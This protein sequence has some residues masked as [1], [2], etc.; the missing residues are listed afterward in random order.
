[1]ANG[2]I[3][4]RQRT[5]KDFR[6]GSLRH[7]SRK[8]PKRRYTEQTID[9]T[10]TAKAIGRS[11]RGGAGEAGRKVEDKVADVEKKLQAGTARI[12]EAAEHLKGK[13]SKTAK[14]A[15]KYLKE[16]GTPTGEMNTAAIRREIERL[17]KEY[18]PKKAER[19]GGKPGSRKFRQR[20]SH[21]AKQRRLERL[22]AV[23]VDREEQEAGFDEG[24]GK[25]AAE[26]EARWAKEQAGRKARGIDLA[27]GE[28]AAAE[29]TPEAL[30]EKD[31][32][33]PV[34]NGRVQAADLG[35]DTSKYKGRTGAGSDAQRVQPFQ[36]RPLHR[37]PITG[38]HKFDMTDPRNQR[39]VTQT[40]PATSPKVDA[41][42]VTTTFPDS[43]DPNYQLP[44]SGGR[45]PTDATSDAPALGQVVN[46]Q[47]KVDQRQVA[48]S[49]ESAAPV[50]GAGPAPDSTVASR[51]EPTSDMVRASAQRVSETP[52]LADQ[53]TRLRGGSVSD[54]GTDEITRRFGEGEALTVDDGLG[55]HVNNARGTIDRID[56][57]ED[58][59]DL[60]TDERISAVLDGRTGA[61]EFNGMKNG[62]PISYTIEVDSD[63][64]VR[65]TGIAKKNVLKQM[66]KDSESLLNIAL[67]T[68]AG[69][70]EDSSFWDRFRE[71]QADPANWPGSYVIPAEYRSP[72]ARLDMMGDQLVGATSLVGAGQAARLAGPAGR[73]IR[74]VAPNVA[75]RVGRATGIGVNP[76]LRASRG[77]NP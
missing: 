44:G 48:T 76:T 3:K 20:S 39:A 33:S 13:V 60:T 22:S 40:A 70:S 14:R 71:E 17:E 18:D 31:I 27:T 10:E 50:A 37:G 4:T 35:M 61:R 53:M 25:L 6:P 21:R 7:D 52:N 64:K 69:R 73:V 59:K 12:G 54:E 2:L 16:G 19:S 41:G 63:G 66:R 11:L 67:G 65:T 1:M 23:L 15:S 74:D 28:Q 77:F 42:P 72:E 38:D 51:T 49:P 30:M 26:E 55:D 57:I 43:R 32:T 75:A 8:G 9:A 46:G 58:Q 45:G 5:D 47:M 36:D 68:D 24:V 62:K 29:E 34:G 56:E